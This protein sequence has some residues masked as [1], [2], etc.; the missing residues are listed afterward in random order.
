MLARTED[1]APLI[2]C[3][4]SGATLRFLLPLAMA[5]G[6]R[7]TTFTGS[8]RL[9]E[10]PLSAPYPVERTERGYRAAAPLMPGRY[11]LRGDE[12]SQTVSGLLMALPLLDAPSQLVLTTPLVSRPYVDM[13]L[14]ALHRHGVTAEETAD[15]WHIPAPQTFRADDGPIEGDWSAAGWWLT[16]DALQRG[17]VT[18]EGLSSQS[19]QSD[20]AIVDYLQRLPESV[21]V[22]QTPDLLPTLALLAAMT[23][24]ATRFTGGAFLRRKESDRL[25]TTAAV[26]SALGPARAS[27]RSGTARLPAARTAAS[28]LCT[29]SSHLS[30]RMTACRSSRVGGSVQESARVAASAAQAR[31]TAAMVA[32]PLWRSA[33]ASAPS[34]PATMTPAASMQAK[35]GTL[36]QA[37]TKNAAE[38]ARRAGAAANATARAACAWERRRS[39]TCAET[40]RS[41]SLYICPFAFA[42]S[43]L[44]GLDASAAHGFRGDVRE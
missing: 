40:M 20:R 6:R 39:G 29:H 14:D 24:Q 2:D 15:G 11:A 34:A 9:L 44:Q 30:H 3:G 43:Q 31:A 22:S 28:S 19:R 12:T 25:R 37:A 32:L 1:G 13:T 41:L 8:P 7:D 38:A 4:D 5:L 18:V 42:I 17:G 36:R 35:A 23:P 16:V 21:D 10:R 26:L 27:V 33:D